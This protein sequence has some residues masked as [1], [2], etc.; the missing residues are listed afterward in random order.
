MDFVD[1]K[2][3]GWRGLIV[4]RL[5]TVRASLSDAQASDD[6]AK[7]NNSF[8]H[9]RY[10][11]RRISTFRP[12]IMIRLRFSLYT[13]RETLKRQLRNVLSSL[14]SLPRIFA[15]AE[16]AGLFPITLALLLLLRVFSAVDQQQPS[17][18]GPP[19]TGQSKPDYTVKVTVPLVTLNVTVLTHDGLFVP[20][21]AKENFRVLEDGES[22]PVVSLGLVEAPITV[23]LLVEYTADTSAIQFGTLRACYG[24]LNTLKS[25][26]WVAVVTFDKE[27]HILE[28]LTQD[29]A[30][31]RH[32]LDT[33]GLPL[34][35]E[36]NLFDAL[37]DTLDRLETVKGRKYVILIASGTDLLSR[38]IYDQ[39][40]KR[41]QSAQNTVIYSLD[42][43]PATLNRQAANE[44]RTFASMT[45]GKLYFPTSAEE[46]ADVFQD[47]GIQ[48]RNQYALSY[49]S[50]HKLEEGTWHKV[51]VEV[52]KP[53]GSKSN[54]QI[55]AREG[56]R[57]ARQAN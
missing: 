24:F 45:G 6:G 41:I 9:I 33:P 14:L 32:A 16:N 7:N 28:D 39:V 22:Q 42:T 11:T 50:T 2:N 19:A 31:V 48:I 26:D 3:L 57:A 18:K 17:L 55:I 12:K 38:K 43:T 20:G 53:D 44:M 5:G 34:W 54:Y 8:F 15:L 35:R 37:Y 52:M 10:I 23:V 1:G 51:K 49:H 13:N 36:A 30:A 21:L 56:Y 29:K 40:L 25:E 46:Y 4:D 47:I 27:L